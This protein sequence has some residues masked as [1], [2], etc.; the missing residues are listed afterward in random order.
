MKIN[1]FYAFIRIILFVIITI[2]LILQVTVLLGEIS[3]VSMLLY[4]TI[5]S[6]ILVVIFLGRS[7]FKAKFGDGYYYT[8]NPIFHGAITLYISITGLIYHLLLASTFMPTGLDWIVN[9]CTHTIAPVFFFIDWLITQKRK[10]YKY[11]YILFWIIFPMVYLVFGT[12]EGKISGHFRYPFMN[13][14]E[15]TGS[16]Y[17]ITISFVISAF[18]ILGLLLVFIN[19]KLRIRA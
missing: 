13:Y 14:I 19:R 18:I 8:G 5:I 12:L 11:K 10:T 3:F 9:L 7:I 15:M 4:F 17:L 1:P 2:A 16:E 6:N